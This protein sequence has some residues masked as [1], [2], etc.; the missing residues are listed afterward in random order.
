MVRFFLGGAVVRVLVHLGY[1]KCASTY[2]QN[3]LFAAAPALRAAGVAYPGTSPRTCHYGLSRHYGF[4][5]EAPDI[6]PTDLG[7]LLDQAADAGCDRVI[8]SSEYLSLCRPSAAA[9]L[10]ADMEH[11]GVHAE[12]VLFSRPLLG[13]VAALFNQYVKT[14]DDGRPLPHIDAFV[15]QVLR[16]RA[17][18]LAGRHAMWQGLVGRRALTHYRL[19]ETSGERGATDILTPFE[20]F[21]GCTINAAPARNANRSLTPDQLYS[22]GQLRGLPK[23]VARDLEIERLVRGGVARE[24]APKDYLRISPDRMARL[25]DE[26]ETPYLGLPWKPLPVRVNALCSLGDAS[27]Q[28]LGQIRFDRARG[29]GQPAPKRG[30]ILA[31][32]QRYA[33]SPRNPIQPRGER[34]DGERC[35]GPA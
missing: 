34:A 21:A 20:A 14:V 8:L 17:I 24:R 26:I 29:V 32:L 19:G 23:G 35:H 28:G 4:G 6:Q 3:S 11:A 13:W 9:R 7:T 22:I 12:Y 15:D 16:N 2:V 18:D 27:A 5:P 31:Q 25:R 30:G 10:V 33:G 1:N